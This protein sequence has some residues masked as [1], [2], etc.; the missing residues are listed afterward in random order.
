MEKIAIVGTGIAGLGCAYFLNP[1][2]ELTLF[3]QNDYAGG[4]S[5]TVDVNDHGR[6]APVD[7]GFMVFNRATYPNL[8]RLFSELRVQPKNTDMSFSVQHRPTRTEFAGSSV[9]HL[10]AQRRNL[11]RP[12]HWRMLMQINRFNSEAVAAL[13]DGSAAQLTLQ[14]FVDR[15]NYGRDFMD[16]YLVPMS[17][18]VWSTPPDLMMQFPAATLLRFFHN[19]GFLGLNTQ[20]QWLTLDGGARTYVKQITKRL[21][22]P[23]RLQRKVTA[24]TRASNGVTIRTDDGEA[25]RFDRVIMAAHADQS[26][27]M[28]KDADQ[29]ERELICEFKYQHNVATLH[30][31]E[32]LMPQAK[33]AW[34]SWNYRVEF[35]STGA[36]KPMTVYWMNQLQGVSEKTNYFVSI[37]GADEVDPA[38]VIRRIDYEHPIFSLG[39]MKAQDRLHLLNNR[40]AGNRVFF[41]GAWFKYGFHEDGFTSA[42]ECCRGL[43]GERIWE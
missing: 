3:E 35:D 2:Y 21:T 10:F 23:V 37:N 34:S 33:L 9:N 8:C 43:T 14:E 5:N 41:C 38:K 36:I 25:H 17:S 30:T 13:E 11:F 4:H 16:L 40:G 26:L 29:L 12:R 28:L 39:A 18:A 27:A 31:D 19:H 32:S 7:T 6:P 15:Q 1:R 42:L 24:V 22:K 20:H